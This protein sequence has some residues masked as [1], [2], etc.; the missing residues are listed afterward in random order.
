[1]VNLLVNKTKMRLLSLLIVLVLV[2][3]GQP[4][5]W[6]VED[7]LMFR[8]QNLQSQVNGMLEGPLSSIAYAL[9]AYC[10]RLLDSRDVLVAILEIDKTISTAEKAYIA[11]TISQYALVP[12]F[13][14]VPDRPFWL[15][16]EYLASLQN[17]LATNDVDSLQIYFFTA[18]RIVATVAATPGLPLHARSFLIDSLSY[19]RPIIME[20]F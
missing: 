8:I 14:P 3:W 2:V 16:Q 15:V 13:V 10:A 9:S 18:Q 12:N 20:L 17:M 19:L 4:I 1:M 7:Q 6:E 5:D 11:R